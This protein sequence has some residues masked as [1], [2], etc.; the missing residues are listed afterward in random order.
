MLEAVIAAFLGGFF[1]PFCGVTVAFWFGS[2][3][4]R[5]AIFA[6]VV[7]F[8]IIS[9]IA[10]EPLAV[11]IGG[12]NLVPAVQEHAAKAVD[13]CVVQPLICR[14]ESA[15]SALRIEGKLAQA[16]L[17]VPAWKHPTSRAWQPSII[18]FVH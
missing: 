3:L 7:G 5:R 2:G 6:A 9:E 13:V 1:P 17:V 15:I 8:G 14:R 18:R 12:R 16:R 10:V 4:K 11:R